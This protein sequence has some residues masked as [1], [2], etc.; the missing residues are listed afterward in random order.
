GAEAGNERVQIL[1]HG[2]G[3]AASDQPAGGLA[4]L[5]RFAGHVREADGA[6]HLIRLSHRDRVP[7]CGFEA[8]SSPFQRPRGSLAR[9]CTGGV[10][11]PRPVPDHP[12]PPPPP[13][14]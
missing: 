3:A 10:R 14:P 11:P 1:V 8:V 4:V 9:L 5:T 12:P 13:P 2:E 7:N 6:N